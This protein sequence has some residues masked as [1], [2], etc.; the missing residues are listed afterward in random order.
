MMPF[1]AGITFPLLS[2]LSLLSSHMKDETP[3]GISQPTH[4]HSN[5]YSE[6]RQSTRAY[7]TSLAFTG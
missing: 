4:L 2:L 1:Y 6:L 3:L 5:S 7:L